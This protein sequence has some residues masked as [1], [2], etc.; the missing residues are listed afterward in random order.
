MG[1]SFVGYINIASIC[2]YFERTNGVNYD[3]TSGLFVKSQVIIKMLY[4]HY[5]AVGKPP[6]PNVRIIR[7]NVSLFHSFYVR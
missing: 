2:R 1:I 4:H 3:L 5:C 6:P 7:Q